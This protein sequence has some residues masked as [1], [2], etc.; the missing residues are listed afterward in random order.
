[1]C[2][3]KDIKYICC[4]KEGIVGHVCLKYISEL[5]S[6]AR[7]TLAPAAIRMSTMSK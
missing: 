3:N 1:M 5:T 6:L 2:I 7:S 4:D